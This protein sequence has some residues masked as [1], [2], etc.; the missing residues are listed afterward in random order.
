MSAT[1]PIVDYPEPLFR[2]V[3]HALR[4]AYAVQD[5][6][7]LPLDPVFQNIAHGGIKIKPSP[8][9]LTGWDK[10]AQSAF[11][12]S[13]LSTLRN[14]YQYIIEGYYS[15]DYNTK[16]LQCRNL[17]II[18]HQTMRNN[19][20]SPWWLVDTCRHNIGLRRHHCDRWWAENMGV[21]PRILL[22]WKLGRTDRSQDG[23]VQYLQDWRDRAELALE[24]IFIDKQIIP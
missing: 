14:Q 10:H 9:I 24:N 8:N 7:I 18:L 11:I 12:L 20:I 4:F 15:R 21:S 3:G 2:S 13:Y 5:H 17:A 19:K 6:P 16:E 1:N 22:Y 23:V